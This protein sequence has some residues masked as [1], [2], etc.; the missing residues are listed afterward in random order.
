MPLT[1]DEF[2]EVASF[3]GHAVWQIQVLEESVALHLVLVHKVDAKTARR[4]A[5]TMFAKT[6]K[7]TLGQLFGAIRDT[8]KEP[9]DLLSRLEH[10]V[11]ERSW[12]IH[13]SRHENRKDLYSDARRPQLIARINA[14]A[15]QALSLL[16]EFQNLTDTHLIARGMD[17][18]KMQ[19]RADEIYRE[20]TAGV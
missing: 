2:S 10:V 16:T 3:V 4:D 1:A 11:D 12:L 7:Q 15:D 18:A 20:W 6:S 5:E 8:G 9:S 17:R 14:V 13:R 19:A